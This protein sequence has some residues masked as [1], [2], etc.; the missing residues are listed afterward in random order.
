VL[1]LF[2]AVRQ[3]LPWKVM[4]EVERQMSQNP[5]ADRSL[6]LNFNPSKGK[7]QDPSEIGASDGTKPEASL[8]IRVGGM[9]KKGTLQETDIYVR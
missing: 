8:P 3:F 1:L 6:A 2:V 9:P 5:A 4:F 7:Y